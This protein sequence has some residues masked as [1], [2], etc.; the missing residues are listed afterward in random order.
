MSI[1]RINVL[2]QTVTAGTPDDTLADVLRAV[3]ETV[4]VTDAT[5]TAVM[6]GLVDIKVYVDAASRAAALSAAAAVDA[7]PGLPAHD[8]P[9]VRYSRPS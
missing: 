6:P 2:T 7:T 5:V 1:Y 4:T 9:T 3:P 8:A